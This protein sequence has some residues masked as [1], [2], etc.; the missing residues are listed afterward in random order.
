MKYVPLLLLSF[1]LVGLS[2]TNGNTQSVYLNAAD[3][4]KVLNELSNRYKNLSSVSQIGTSAGGSAIMAIAIGAGNRDKKPALLVMGGVDPEDLSGPA[5]SV[6]FA[7]FLLE[8]SA[9]DSV[10]SV[11][12]KFTI[13]IVPRVSPDPLEAYFRKPLS[14]RQGNDQSDDADRDGKQDEDGPNDVNGDGLVSMMRVM[15][16]TGPW[17]IH[18]ANPKLMRKADA[19]KGDV[20]RYLLLREG[21]D[22][23]GDKKVNE[24]GSGG[25]NVNKNTTFNPVIYT[26]DGGRHPF[27]AVEA[28]ALADFIFERPNILATFTFSYVDNVSRAWKI[29]YPRTPGPN[30]FTAD[31]SAHA[32]LTAWLRPHATYTGADSEGGD[33][34]SWAYWH[35]GRFSFGA[36]AWSFPADS[37]RRGSNSGSNSGNSNSATGAGNNAGASSPN[38]ELQALKWYE[39]NDPS[40]FTPWTPINHPDYPG[41]TVEIG[42]FKPFALTNAPTAPLQAQAA[43]KA[44]TLL[45]HLASGLPDLSVGAPRIEDLGGRV[46]RVTLTATNQGRVPTHSEI[47]RLVKGHTAFLF[48]TKLAKGQKLLMGSPTTFINEP[49]NGGQSRTQTFLISGSGTVQ[50]EIG[51]PATGMRTV[52]VNLN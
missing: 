34:T 9:S 11:L 42:W 44:T 40:G 36:P 22:D 5:S 38:H 15:D 45:F 50:F 43:K 23:D 39:A 31:S 16:P 30:R 35:A 27:E 13:Y 46:Y 12:E 52:S 21:K 14:A 33:L 47:G 41:Q 10:K 8:Q 17:M 29:K 25:I 24:D 32:Q 6:Q 3:E 49:L 26:S 4:A 7:R 1:F 18:E 48:K 28:R 51:N 20:G 19:R 37:V 2:S